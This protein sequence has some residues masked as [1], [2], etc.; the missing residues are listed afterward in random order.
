[1]ADF[2]SCNN[3]AAEAA[4][5]L[6]DGHAVDLLQT[7]VYD[8]SSTDISESFEIQQWEIRIRPKRKIN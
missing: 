2:M 8:A 7:L 5:I 3:D 4:G 1:M 6:D